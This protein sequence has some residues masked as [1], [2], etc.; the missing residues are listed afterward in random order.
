MFGAPSYGGS[1]VKNEFMDAVYN[2][3][4]SGHEDQKGAIIPVVQYAVGTAGPA[5]SSTLFYNGNSSTPEIV[6][7][8]LGDTITPLNSST[9]LLPFSLGQYSK[10]VRPPFEEGGQSYGLRQR[11]HLLPIMAKRE[12]MQLVHD[13]YFE[14]AQLQFR[15]VE[16]GVIGMAFNPITTQLLAASNKRPG[17]LQGL[18]QQP[19]SW[20][21][22]TYSWKNAADDAVVDEFIQNFNTDM[23]R[24]LKIMN[25]TGSFYY[26]NEADVDQPVFQNYP[27]TNLQRLEEIRCKYDPERVCTELMPGGFKV[28]DV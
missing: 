11:F 22:Q 7:G 10:Q 26:L 23:L 13:S 8:F 14:A 3:V 16:K 18:D 21:E 5:Y 28:A 15:D 24:R 4:T 12:A 27:A 1:E 19:A 9:T 20:I 6:K 2:F 17:S 25:A